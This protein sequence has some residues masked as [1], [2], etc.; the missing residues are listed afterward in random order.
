[1]KKAIT[2]LLLFCIT[3]CCLSGCTVVTPESTLDYTEEST[4]STTTPTQVNY[5]GYYTVDRELLKIESEHY[6]PAELNVGYESLTSKAMRVCYNE[7][8][9]S[10][11][12]ISEEKENDRDVY[13][14]LK[15]ELKDY[16]LTEAELRIVMSAYFG[17]HPEVFW[18]DNNFEYAVSST[19]TILQLF[20]FMSGAEIETAAKEMTEKAEEILVGMDAGMSEYNR[21]LYIH[22][23]V[24]EAC[25][26]AEDVTNISDDYLAFTTYGALVN[27]DVVCEGYSRTFQ[28]LLSAVG[29]ES[30]CV[31][32]VGSFDLHMWNCVNID[33]N[34][35]YVD[36]TWDE[37]DDMGICYDYF[38]LTTQQLEIDHVI[39]ATFSEFTDE[40]I[41][42]DDWTSPKSFNIIT[43]LCEDDNMSYYYQNG[44]VI[45]GFDDENKER[46]SKAI[47][48]AAES[49]EDYSFTVY[50][51]IDKT[52]M[53]FDY[54]VDN[55]FYSGEYFI[56]EC[57]D[58][59]NSQNGV[60]IDRNNVS[61][62]K[63]GP[64][65]S[66]NVYLTT[67]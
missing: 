45:D 37:D 62:R 41:C 34:W 64:L 53:Y 3:L 55:L 38:N 7:I 35:Y 8:D 26:Y 54:A 25:V 10:V 1:M 24:V 4:V 21:E 22:D 46:L 56:F 57:I 31:L 47:I 40:E 28:M 20:S 48:N 5:D 49:S 13:S 51:G 18:T 50:I 30:Y 33:D 63:V 61:V 12:Y 9:K 42:G 14:T 65:A 36:T 52:S 59:V 29:I 6:S 11:Y 17:D 39:N 15:I 43:P 27:S 66:V 32:G 67:E 58:Y 16:E 44:V 60:Q 2:I 19:K 23:A